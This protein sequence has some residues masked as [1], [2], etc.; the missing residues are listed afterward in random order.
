MVKMMKKEE[1]HAQKMAL[2]HHNNIRDLIIQSGLI[3][4]K[5]MT[6]YLHLVS[7]EMNSTIILVV[8]YLT[9]WKEKNMSIALHNGKTTSTIQKKYLIQK[10][11]IM[12]R[13]HMQKSKDNLLSMK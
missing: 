13:N 2:Y 7:M 11:N 8:Q 9:K 10:K 3:M 4:H 5:N 12:K 1:K 6:A